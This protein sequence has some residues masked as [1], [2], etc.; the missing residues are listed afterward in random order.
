M[1]GVKFNIAVI[2]LGIE[3]ITKLHEIAVDFPGMCVNNIAVF[4]QLGANTEQR[5]WP[6]ILLKPQTKIERLI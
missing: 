2:G 3:I 1:F 4:V 5:D 6:I